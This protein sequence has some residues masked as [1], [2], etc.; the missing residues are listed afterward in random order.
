VCYRPFER[1]D[2]TGIQPDGHAGEDFRAALRLVDRSG[3][4]NDSQKHARILKK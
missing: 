3:L 4:L 2:I 1:I